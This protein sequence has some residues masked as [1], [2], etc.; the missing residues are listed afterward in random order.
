MNQIINIILFDNSGKNFTFDNIKTFKNFLMQE[1]KFWEDKKESINQPHIFFNQNN[2]LEQIIN[3]IDSWGD[4]TS[5]TDIE[6]GNKISSLQTNSLRGSWLWSGHPYIEIFIEASKISSDT[7]TGFIEATLRNNADRVNNYAYLKGYILAYEFQ[8]QGKSELTKRQ[9]SEEKSY[10]GLRNKLESETT[11]IIS[12]VNGLENNIN[13]LKDKAK[14]Y[15][16]NEKKLYFKSNKKNK[17]SF[18]TFMNEC[19]TEIKDLEKTYHEKLRLE[20]PASYWNKKAL[21]YRNQGILWSGV[22]GILLLIGLLEFS[23]FFT[24]WLKAD[25]KSL[26]LNSLQGAVLFITIVTIYAISIKTISKLVFSSFHLQRDAEEREQLTHVYLSLI[27]ENGAIDEESRKIV[28]QALFS[29]ADSGLLHKDSN[30]TMPGI[31][32]LA[33][34][35]RGN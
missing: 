32:E 9:I 27:N 5:L 25:S 14:Q 11:N 13:E 8:M 3:T 18:N 33:K 21:T 12:K 6:I 10:E 7:A 26:K 1:R 17:Q 30:P 34:A 19:K 20:K 24:D 28:L 23:S 15:L 4:I 31:T 35:T 2:L 16:I 29:R 22:L